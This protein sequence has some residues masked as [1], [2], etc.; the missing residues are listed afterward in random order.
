GSNASCGIDWRGHSGRAGAARESEDESRLRQRA[1]RAVQRLSPRSRVLLESE[2]PPSAVP[3]TVPPA[4]GLQRPVA[5]L[6]SRRSGV[7]SLVL[8]FLRHVDCVY[9]PWRLHVVEN[10]KLKT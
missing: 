10:L 3:I 1:R 8:S 4:A 2:D 6:R 9:L 7:R 5:D